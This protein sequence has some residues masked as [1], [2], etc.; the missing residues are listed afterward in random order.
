MY[1][2]RRRIKPHF[3]Q[4]PYNNSS[5][6]LGSQLEFVIFLKESFMFRQA[7]FWWGQGEPDK[8]P[9]EQ[10]E[11]SPGAGLSLWLPICSAFA[12]CKSLHKQAE[13]L[14]YALIWTRIH[15]HYIPFSH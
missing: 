7:Y 8:A 15:L 11:A 2:A 5:I 12:F 10:R 9:E 6:F 13:Y 4:Q 14:D 1:V 3:W